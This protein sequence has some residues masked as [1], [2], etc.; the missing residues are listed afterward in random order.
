MKVLNSYSEGLS[1]TILIS[2]TFRKRGTMILLLVINF[3]L[4]S[5]SLSLVLQ[6]FSDAVNF[7]SFQ[8]NFFFSL[9]FKAFLP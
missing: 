9:L 3:Q 6:F 2:L 7:F 5:L 4:H 8:A 1:S